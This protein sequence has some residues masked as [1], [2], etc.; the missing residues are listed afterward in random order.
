MPPIAS[1]RKFKK[2]SDDNKTRTAQQ[3]QGAYHATE[4]QEY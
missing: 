4:S 2:N 3:S 1:K